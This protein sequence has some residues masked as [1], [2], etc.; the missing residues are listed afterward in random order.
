MRR[1]Y[2]ALG[3]GGKRRLAAQDRRRAGSGRS[4][5]GYRR[6]DG[7]CDAQFRSR[8]PE[9]PTEAPVRDGGVACWTA[10][11]S[12][13]GAWGRRRRVSSPRLAP[14]ARRW[15]WPR[16]EPRSSF[17][18]A[19]H[20]QVPER[21]WRPRERLT[22]SDARPLPCAGASRARETVAGGQ[23]RQ[24]EACD[25]HAEDQPERCQR[26]RTDS[27]PADRGGHGPPDRPPPG[28]AKR[29]SRLGRL[30]RNARHFRCG[31]GRHQIPSM[32]WPAPRAG[33]HCRESAASRPRA[34]A[35]QAATILAAMSV[36]P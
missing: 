29:V 34:H 3:A 18:R 21:P 2:P 28:H 10:T 14:G 19:R 17:A 35:G 26:A 20:R 9:R 6:R 7:A 11:K 33:E 15:T 13:S 30:R 32:D 25:G 22:S 8:G 4:P 31:R 23:P 24:P 36:A 16:M 12:G 1:Q 27:T 5:K